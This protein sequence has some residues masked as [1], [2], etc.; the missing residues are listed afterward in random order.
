ML[1]ASLPASA[2]DGDSPPSRTPSL[3]SVLH[4]TGGGLGVTGGHT[5]SSPTLASGDPVGGAI[6]GRRVHGAGAPTSPATGVRQVEDG[7]WVPV[8]LCARACACACACVC[9]CVC[10][11]ACECVCVCVRV[12]VRVRVHACVCMCA[13]ACAC[14]RVRVR[15]HVCVCVCV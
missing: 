4:T 10:M 3:P 7:A 9:V 5:L 11:R 2:Y 12:C 1:A 15:V 6:V 14:V 8:Y 13:C